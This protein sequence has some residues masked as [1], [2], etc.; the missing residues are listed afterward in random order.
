MKVVPINWTDVLQVEV[1]K[2][3][4]WCKRSQKTF[5]GSANSRVGHPTDCSKLEKHLF[6]QTVKTTVELFSSNSIQVPSQSTNGWGI[7]STIVV[8][9]YHKLAVVVI[10]NVVK[11]LPG[12]SSGERAIANNRDDVAV[13]LLREFVCFGNSICP[14]KR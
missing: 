7:G 13:V 11:R 1:W 6:A 3:T 8:D 2:H 10:G 4:L 5:S 14:R 12:H 9:N